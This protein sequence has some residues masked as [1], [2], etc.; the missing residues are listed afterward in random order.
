MVASGLFSGDNR[1][2]LDL[3]TGV[4]G[5][6]AGGW[7]SVTKTEGGG[8]RTNNPQW[9]R[10]RVAGV[11]RDGTWTYD[12]SGATPK[13]IGPFWDH[14]RNVGY[15]TFLI[16]AWVNMDSGRGQA[17]AREYVTITNPA[18]RPQAPTNVGLDRITATGMRYRF[19]GNWDG[20]SPILRYEYQCAETSAMN[21]PWASTGMS[22]EVIRN[23]L[24][25]GQPHF[26]RARAVNAIGVSDPSPIISAST[27]GTGAPGLTIAPSLAGTSATL[28]LTPPAT[29]STVSRYNIQRRVAGTTSPVTTITTTSNSVES[30]GLTPGTSY[31]YRVQAD[32]HAYLSPWSEWLLSVQ[33]NPNT[34]PGDYFDGSSAPRG[35]VSFAWLGAAHASRSEAR[36]RG[37]DGWMASAD[38]G[39]SAVLQ[40]ITGGKAGQFA[41]RA[42][43]IADALGAG[44]QVG[45]ANVTGRRAVIEEQTTYVGSIFARPSRPQ[46]LRAVLYWFD[47]AGA[48]VGTPVRGEASVLGPG[49]YSRLVVSGVSPASAEFALARVEDVAGEGW[50]AWKAGEHLDVDAAMVTLGALFDYFDGSTPDTDDYRYDWLG[51]SQ[52][53]ASSRTPLPRGFV[54][55]M[56]D[57]DCA[58]LPLPPSP[59]SIPSDCITEVGTWRRYSVLIPATEV[60]QWGSAVTTLILETQAFPE[61]QVRIRYYPNPD[62][63]PVEQLD[64]TAWEGEQIITYI[65][66]NTVVT[67]DGVR[68]RVRA[69]VGGREEVSA[70]NVLYGTGGVPP[71]WATMR[72]GVAYVV[73]LDVPLEAPAGNLKSEVLVTQRM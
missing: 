60:G 42:V 41:A 65:P 40:Q 61:R 37:V 29:I 33:P 56:A 11:D 70:A 1:Y 69:S 10:I 12:F 43:V 51:V 6:S 2:R 35:D 36:G 52:A 15:G 73:T 31:E 22:G 47:A 14:W 20:G 49:Q 64:M 53:S 46:R 19:S 21:V 18:T 25:P 68:R 32:I 26:W 63:L 9:V 8:Y 16:E 5:T 71:T 58:P 72:C 66:A 44:L 3:F 57:P 23:D 54:D 28:R 48:S 38:G 59:P 34:N 27:A 24:K 62:N 13:T 39:G 30:A 50:V 45:M 17:Y 67:V 4:S 55:L 7:V